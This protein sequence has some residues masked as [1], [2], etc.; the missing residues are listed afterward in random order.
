MSRTPEG[1]TESDHGAGENIQPGESTTDDSLAGAREA[2]H[3][4][5]QHVEDGAVQH[6]PYR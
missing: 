4:E 3:R 1:P 5:Y 6:E 2:D